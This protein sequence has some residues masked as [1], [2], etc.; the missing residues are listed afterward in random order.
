MDYFA[1]KEAYG[2]LVPTKQQEVFMFVW[3]SAKL[4]YHLF[5]NSDLGKE[6]MEADQ[7]PK[8]ENWTDMLR[9]IY[10]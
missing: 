4:G 1:S 8:C 10:E 7:L 2:L 3:L 6:P 5:Q 9:G